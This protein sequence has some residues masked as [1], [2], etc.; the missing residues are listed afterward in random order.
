M[1]VL[2][3]FLALDLVFLLSLS[4]LNEGDWWKTE[5]EQMLQAR[6][7]LRACLNGGTC[8]ESNLQLLCRK[9]SYCLPVDNTVSTRITNNSSER[10]SC[11]LWKPQRHFQEWC[12][13][14]SLM[15]RR[16]REMIFSPLARGTISGC[17]HEKWSSFIVRT[18]RMILSAQDWLHRRRGSESRSNRLLLSVRAFHISLWKDQDPSVLGIEIGLINS[19]RKS[20][21]NDGCIFTVRDNLNSENHSSPW[22]Y[23]RGNML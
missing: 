8:E 21:I 1:N 7:C 5:S 4:S 22:W 19:S 10:T 9:C 14:P 2:Q 16:R 11:A 23:N 6:G 3:W 13:L 20:E 18:E 15:V 12:R 17:V